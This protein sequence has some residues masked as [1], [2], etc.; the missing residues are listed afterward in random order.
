MSSG[1]PVPVPACIER[2]TTSGFSLALTLSTRSWVK[3]AAS[4]NSMPLYLSSGSQLLM[5]GVTIPIMATF[6][7]PLF[8][9][10]Y[11]WK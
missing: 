9:T 7:P 11:S 1:F 2:I 10:V 3:P 8:K 5:R 4:L 6:S